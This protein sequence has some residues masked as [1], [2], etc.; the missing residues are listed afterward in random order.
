MQ[1]DIMASKIQSPKDNNANM[2][3]AWRRWKIEFQLFSVVTE[4]DEKDDKKRLLRCRRV[5]A[6]EVGKYIIIRRDR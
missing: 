1:K 3:E 4:T 6:R 2:S 5:L